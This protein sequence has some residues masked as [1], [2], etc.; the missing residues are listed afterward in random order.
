MGNQSIV[1]EVFEDAEKVSHREGM[2]EGLA[3]RFQ[4]KSFLFSQS[5]WKGVH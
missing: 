3:W 5:V 1:G 2:V 4:P